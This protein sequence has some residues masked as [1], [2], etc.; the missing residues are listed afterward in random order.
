MSLLQA[1]LSYAEYGLPV[2]PMRGKLALTPH[3]F[4]DPSTDADQT[5]GWWSQWPD[6]NI[7]I[8]TSGASGLVGSTLTPGMRN[9]SLAAL[10]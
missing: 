5:R 7:A 1:A 2:F 9:A 8:P 10:E 6:S 4:K 3:V